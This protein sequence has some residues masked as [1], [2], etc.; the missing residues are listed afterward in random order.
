[1]ILFLAF[2]VPLLWLF[3]V[4]SRWERELAPNRLAW[5]QVSL[6]GILA[7]ILGLILLT[8]L[9][10]LF[11]F[12]W[13]PRV[14]L[15]GSV[16][17]ADHLTPVLLSV[18]A[19]ILVLQGITRNQRGGAL[20]LAVSS[21]LCGWFTV[22]GVVEAVTFWGRGDPYALILMPLLRV[23]EILALA[24]LLARFHPWEGSD[25]FLALLAAAAVALIGALP[26]FLYDLAY[27]GLAVILAA[28][29][30]LAVLAVFILSFRRVFLERSAGIPIGL[31]TG[32]SARTA[33]RSAPNAAGKSA[34]TARAVSGTTDKSMS[35]TTGKS[36]SGTPGKPASPVSSRR[37]SPP[38]GRRGPGRRV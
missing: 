13:R 29:A 24:P 28:C 6:R 31:A 7:G 21:F 33:D 17:L 30:L 3:L 16:L 18:G 23:A 14:L 8:Q 19:A 27:R 36:V 4:Y 15:F 9:R 1:M 2:S 12:A 26:S 5:F 22:P 34:A 37:R 32:T 10:R 35:G 38:A 20:F 11:G 25:G